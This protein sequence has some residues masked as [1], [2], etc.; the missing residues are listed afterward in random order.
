M[1]DIILLAIGDTITLECAVDLEECK[2][3]VPRKPVIQ[4]VEVFKVDLSKEKTNECIK[5]IIG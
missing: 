1:A 3:R 4:R 5:D 2:N